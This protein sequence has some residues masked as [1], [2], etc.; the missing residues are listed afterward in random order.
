MPPPAAAPPA[1]T[2]QQPPRR[3][4][5]VRPFNMHSEIRAKKR[6]SYD[7]RNAARLEEQKAQE[8]ARQREEEEQQ[9]EEYKQNRKRTQFHAHPLPKFYVNKTPAH[10][11]AAP[12]DGFDSD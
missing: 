7:R 8:L 4:T 9:E 6:R 5:D 11:I 1:A 12:N 2:A 10:V 3:A